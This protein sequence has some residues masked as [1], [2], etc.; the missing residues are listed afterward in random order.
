MTTVTTH[1]L[2]RTRRWAKGL[3][4]KEDLVPQTISYLL[5]LSHLPDAKVCMSTEFIT[6]THMHT[7]THTHTHMHLTLH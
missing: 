1:T 5:M 2:A 7:H 6:C 3:K 4:G